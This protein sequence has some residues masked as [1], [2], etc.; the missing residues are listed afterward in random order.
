MKQADC[1]ETAAAQLISA[2]GKNAKRQAIQTLVDAL[3]AFDKSKEAFA[4]EVF[5]EIMIREQEMPRRHVAQ[6][7]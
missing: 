5:H 3:T 7:A 1:P 2:F 4:R 6:V